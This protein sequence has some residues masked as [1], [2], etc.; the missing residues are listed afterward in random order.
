MMRQIKGLVIG[1]H[2]VSDRDLSLCDVLDVA[3]PDI[4]RD[5]LPDGLD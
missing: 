5:G 2:S 1:V 3:L 4:G